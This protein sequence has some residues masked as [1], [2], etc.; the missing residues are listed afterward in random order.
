MDP[1]GDAMNAPTPFPREALF[2]KG[3]QAVSLRKLC[4]VKKGSTKLTMFFVRSAWI[5]WMCPSLRTMFSIQRV[6]DVEQR[7]RLPIFVVAF[8][9]RR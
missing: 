4:Y 6:G 2:D 9:G 7:C 5:G 3:Y 8:L 1:V